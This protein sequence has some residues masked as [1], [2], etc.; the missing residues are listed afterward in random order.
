[1][2]VIVVG[3]GVIGAVTAYRLARA[4][5]QVT[6]IEAGQ[7]ANAASGASFGWINASFYLD[8]DHFRLRYAG[9]AAHKRLAVDLG[10]E[11]ISWPGCLCWE[12]SGAA[13][14]IHL[15]ALADLGYPVQE[16]GADAFARL[17]PAMPAP[18]RA[19]YLPGEGVVDLVQLTADAMRGAMAQGA[20]WITGVAAAGFDMTSDRITGVRTDVGTFAADKVV[21]AA[22]VATQ[23]LLQGVDVAVPM[24]HRPA[25]ILRSEPLPP[26]MR[27]VLVAPDQEVR[28]TPQGHL[29]APTTAGHQGDSADGID[30]APDVLADAAIARISTL[31]GRDVAWEQVTLAARPMPADTLPVIGPCGPAGLYVATLHSGATLAAVVAE[32]VSAEVRDT[33]LTN[34]QTAMLAPYRPARFTG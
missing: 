17:E 30:A 7:P 18:D 31:I 3:S 19:L 34:A 29:L 13:F 6:V 33:A 24:V 1:M 4:G 21:V 28:Q 25:L 27:H 16:I 20:R 9:M 26:L 11:A 2:K 8:D 15:R 5:V 22:G 10:S 12:H 14:D 32:L 23:T